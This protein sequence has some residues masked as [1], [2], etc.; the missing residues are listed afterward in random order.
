MNTALGQNQ[1]QDRTSLDTLNS[2]PTGLLAALGP[3]YSDSQGLTNTQLRLTAN[4]ANLSAQQDAAYASQNL[5]LERSGTVFANS[6]SAVSAASVYVNG[7]SAVNNANQIKSNSANIAYANANAIE[8]ASRD[9]SYSAFLTTEAATL[10]Q[11]RISTNTMVF[12]LGNSPPYTNP[13]NLQMPSTISTLVS[14]FKHESQQ[15]VSD[16]SANVL[17]YINNTQTLLNNAIVKSS[18]VS[19]NLILL[20]ALNTFVKTVAQVLLF[21]LSEI[22]GKH[23]LVIQNVPS[24]VLACGIN[25]ANAALVFISA[26]RSKLTDNTVNLSTYIIAADLY[27]N[28]LSSIARSND[29]NMYLQYAIQNNLIT[30]ARTMMEYGTQIAI[31]NNNPY[32][33]YGIATA[34]IQASAAAASAKVLAVA[35]VNAA[36][37]SS[38]P[39][40]V[41]TAE[42]AVISTI[43]AGG[44]TAQISSAVSNYSSVVATAESAIVAAATAAAAISPIDAAD[45]AINADKSACN[46][47]DIYN[48]MTNLSVAFTNTTTREALIEPTINTSIASIVSMLETVATITNNYSPQS[49]TSLIRRAYN[50]IS[51]VL[52]KY[53]EIEATTV[54]AA[55]DASSV[56]TLLNNA[57]SIVPNVSDT[58]SIQN[59][60]WAANAASGKA[61]EVSDKLKEVAFLFSRNAHNLVTSQRLAIQTASANR[62]GA[63]YIYNTARITRLSNPVI[64]PPVITNNGFKATIRAKILP[65]INVRP[66]LETLIRSS[67]V[68][69]LRPDSLRSISDTRV[70]VGQEIQQLKDNSI[71]SFRQQ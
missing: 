58:V 45:M 56:L 55:V 71:F 5:A 54:D 43:K 22:Y 19:T 65:P 6:D 64:Q 44:T 67:T 40:I 36:A 38:Y 41:G 32:S 39:G 52:Q 7:A 46:A 21:P 63:Q 60:L 8:R 31:P 57:Y 49:A 15:N 34:N 35:A 29:L 13:G 24:I 4:Q 33:P 37:S 14:Q 16:A 23:T 59:K 51:A 47:R 30:S 61:R 69:S 48:V 27:A 10:L 11:D 18:S 12:Q 70:K 1:V 17:A 25:L 26:L 20:G 68:D 28:S 53:T 62:A 42:S 3:Y 9:A 66:S 50:T 2:Y